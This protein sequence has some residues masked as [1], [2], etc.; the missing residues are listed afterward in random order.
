MISPCATPLLVV[1]N[2]SCDFRNEGVVHAEIR[3]GGHP[4]QVVL[5][6]ASIPGFISYVKMPWML[7]LHVPSQQAVVR[8]MTRCHEGGT[9]DL[10]ADLS[11]EL[12][13]SNPPSP[14]RF[15]PGEDARRQQEAAFIDLDLTDL[16]HTETY[17]WVFRGVIRIDGEPVDIEVQ[18]YAGPGCI[19]VTR[20]MRRS[21]KLTAAE[22]DAIRSRLLRAMN[23]DAT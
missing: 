19:P 7:E 23:I 6:F 22:M 14:F 18:L 13:Q 12:T 16:Q 2:I 8:L 4:L 11:E 21:R 5:D 3:L 20:W 17:P 15:D 1:D 9:V 10:P